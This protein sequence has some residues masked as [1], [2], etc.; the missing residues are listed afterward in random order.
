MGDETKELEARPTSYD[1][2]ISH[3]SDD[4]D[5]ARHLADELR[6]RGL[7]PWFDETDLKPGVNWAQQI[8]EAIDHS[9]FCVVVLSRTSSAS[10]PWI[11]KEWASIQ[12]CSWRRPEMP[13]CSLRLEDIEPPPFLREWQSVLC[14]RNTSDVRSAADEIV[15]LLL[16]GLKK[17]R[18]AARA[19][20]DVEALQRF[21]EI[22]R[23]LRHLARSKKEESAE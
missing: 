23:A 10:K 1:V 14:K 12:E 11:S 17:E 5:V 15:V 2:F 8:R 19:A 20:C 13:I 7:R 22:E 18:G 16:H 21:A 6:L 9:R 4:R 3:A